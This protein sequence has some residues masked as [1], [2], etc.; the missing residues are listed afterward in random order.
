MIAAAE[1]RDP[2]ESSA[3]SGFVASTMETTVDEWPTATVE[4]TERSTVDETTMEMEEEPEV[5]S[6]E[7]ARISC[8]ETNL[9]ALS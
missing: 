2:F 9:S 1:E 7:E 5:S 4:T 3:G 8:Y 6:K